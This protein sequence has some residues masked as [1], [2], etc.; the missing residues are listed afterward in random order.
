MIRICNKAAA[1]V[2][3][4]DPIGMRQHTVADFR[5]VRTEA[6]NRT[7]DSVMIIDMLFMAAEKRRSS[8]GAGDWRRII[9]MR[10]IPLQHPVC[11]NA[12]PASRRYANFFF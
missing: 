10:G 8:I 11:S 12:P 6:A 5:A 9:V 4:A 7:G 1:A 2:A 3:G